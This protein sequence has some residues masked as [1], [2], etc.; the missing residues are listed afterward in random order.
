MSHS[1]EPCRT[2]CRHLVYMLRKELAPMQRYICIT[3]SIF[4]VL[5]RAEGL[6]GNECL[7]ICP[8]MFKNTHARAH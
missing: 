1:P 7:N 3:V 8:Q 2:T 6:V 5:K 4:R